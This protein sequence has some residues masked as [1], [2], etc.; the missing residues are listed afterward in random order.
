[1]RPPSSAAKPRL[2]VAS[3]SIFEAPAGWEHTCVIREWA[4][5]DTIRAP[6]AGVLRA[7]VGSG[8]RLRSPLLSIKLLASG[9]RSEK[10]GP[11]PPLLFYVYRPEGW[12]PRGLPGLREGGCMPPSPN[13]KLGPGGWGPRGLPGLM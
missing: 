5:R 8:K 2:I 9:D 3:W 12:R 4:L 10:G 6:G 13:F 7:I 1:M 11:Q